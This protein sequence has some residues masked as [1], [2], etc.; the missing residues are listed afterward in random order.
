[1]THAQVLIPLTDIK[2]SKTNPRKYFDQAKLAE[3][4]ASVKEHGVLQPVLVRG[5]GKGYELVAGERRLRA[6]TSS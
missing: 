5:N 1:M 6:A 4:A 2:P 3:L